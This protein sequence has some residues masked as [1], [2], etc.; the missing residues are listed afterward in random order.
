VS[1]IFTLIYLY[2]ASQRAVYRVHW[3]RARAQLHRW[4]EEV[5]LTRNEMHWTINYF[6]FRQGQWLLWQSSYPYVTQGHLAYAERQKAMWA[7]IGEQ[8]RRLF[9]KIWADFDSDMSV[10]NS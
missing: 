4:Q 5:A 9:K 3:L 10:F 1:E 6:T 7:E 8:A 2:L